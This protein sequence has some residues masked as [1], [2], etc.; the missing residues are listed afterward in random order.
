MTQQAQR[1]LFQ[2]RQSKLIQGINEVTL[3]YGS[4]PVYFKKR[5]DKRLGSLNSAGDKADAMW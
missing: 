2:R 4:H 1:D 5:C 3:Y